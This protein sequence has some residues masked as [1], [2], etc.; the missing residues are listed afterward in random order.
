MNTSLNLSFETAFNAAEKVPYNAK[1][2]WTFSP[3]VGAVEA[4]TGLGVV[5]TTSDCGQRAIIIP[6]DDDSVVI[7]EGSNGGSL[8]ISAV[9]SDGMPYMIRVSKAEERVWEVLLDAIAFSQS[10]R[11]LAAA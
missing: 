11:Q 10:F 8:Q 1:W 2:A 3:F 7:C 6:T 9:D 5:A 4:Y